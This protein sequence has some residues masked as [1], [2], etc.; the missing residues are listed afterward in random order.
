MNARRARLAAPAVASGAVA[1]VAAA[2]LAAHLGPRYDELHTLSHLGHRTPGELWRSYREARDTLPPSGYLL[3]WGWARAVGTDLGDARALIVVSWATAAAALSLLVRRAG[4]WP[5]L[6]AGLAPSATALLYLGA[7]ARP[8]AP[9]LAAAALGTLAWQRA[10]EV[11]R[12]GP[13]VAAS[14]VGFA[15]ATALH[16]L[17]AP[18]ALCATGASLASGWPSSRRSPRALAPSLGSLLP[19]VVSIPLY[20][21]ASADQ[22]RLERSVRPLDLVVFWPSVLR[23]ALVVAVAAVLV[24]AVAWAAGR[25]GTPSGLRRSSGLG[26]ELVW[27]GLAVVLLVPVSGVV[28]MALTSG[29]YV[30]RYGV[31]SLIG[32]AVL[33]A[34]AASWL[35]DRAGQRG[36]VLGPALGVLGVLAVVVASR[37]IAT[38]FVSADAVD[39]LPARLGLA[40]SGG[41]DAIVLVLDEYDAALLRWSGDA[42][43]DRRLVLVG[44]TTIAGAAGEGGADPL[45]APGV[46]RIEAVGDPGEVQALLAAHPGW[47]ARLLAEAGYVRPGVDRVL[48]RYEVL[49]PG[50]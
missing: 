22:G 13:W 2:A 32:L 12:A 33:V 45:E 4:P 29:T 46:G 10:G 43:L 8:Y 38:S 7:F 14:A 48:G 20:A 19:L 36:R 27:F 50:P 31:G 34:A 30:H 6:L 15:V 39:A 47:S 49:P 40:T 9:A 18:V 3:A 35:V 42:G 41:D 11:D 1:L 26:S 25:R 17:V 28:A 37:S 23:P 44:P 5:A 16:Y 21:Q 24:A